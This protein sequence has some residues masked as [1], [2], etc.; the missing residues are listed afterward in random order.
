[1]TL[2]RQHHVGSIQN[3]GSRGVGVVLVVVGCVVGVVASGVAGGSAVRPI[4]WLAAGDS[5]SAGFGLAGETGFC[6]ADADNAWPA[7]TRA[8]VGDRLDVA[9]FDVGACSG[10]VINDFDGQARAG[11]R[12]DLV[13]FSFGGNDVG[14]SSAVKICIAGSVLDKL[15]TGQVF[16]WLSTPIAGC[17]PDG[18]VR[19]AIDAVAGG[20]RVFLGRV[21][22]EFM[23]S[24]GNVVVVGYPALIEDPG[25]WSGIARVVGLCQGINATGARRIRG[26]AGALNAAIGGAVRDVNAERPNGVHFTFVNV[27]DGAGNAQPFGNPRTNPNL[28][29]PDGSSDRH[30]LCG[31][32]PWM[33]GIG[34]GAFHPTI[35]GHQAEANLISPIITHLDWSTLTT[36]RATVHADRQTAAELQTLLQRVGLDRKYR[37]PSTPVE[38]WA[39]ELINADFA[40][41][42]ADLF[43]Q[44]RGSDE[45]RSCPGDP[46]STYFQ[47]R[48]FQIIQ[49]A[50]AC[51]DCEQPIADAWRSAQETF[52]GHQASYFVMSIENGTP[53]PRPVGDYVFGHGLPAG[54]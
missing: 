50:Y 51:G 39:I 42:D 45:G 24:G 5:Y 29:E 12:Y 52:A 32:A 38:C 36:N 54:Q 28:F 43:E 40:S 35:Q 3:V 22:Q 21:A 4:V 18:L 14:F 16:H 27:Q 53:F 30:N 48:N 47:I 2:K 11:T 33:N 19:D 15:P 25:R 8:R 23:N 17:P 9:G 1:M 44:L 41:G 10:A 20:Y 13:T 46:L 49:E 26:W 34:G 6:R 31:T 7:L 37:D